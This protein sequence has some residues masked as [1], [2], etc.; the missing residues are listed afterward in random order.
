MLLLEYLR[1]DS[2]HRDETVDLHGLLLP[3]ANNTADCLR[4]PCLVQLLRWRMQGREE[5]RVVRACQVRPACALVAD[6]EQQNTFLAAVL[7]L[8]QRG[9]AGRRAA[10]DLEVRDLVVVKR[11]RDL[12]RQVGELDEQENAFVLWQA[13]EA[14]GSANAQR[15]V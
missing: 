15:V 2:V 5:D 12:L 3:I 14:N 7:E 13:T 1:V 8:V 4:L 9:T 6:V 10:L 11:L